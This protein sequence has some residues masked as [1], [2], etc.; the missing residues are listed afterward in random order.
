MNT[1]LL[2][3]TAQSYWLRSA[4]FMLSILLVSSV[5]TG[6]G[7]SEDDSKLLPPV[8][9][10]AGDECHV[11][12]MI[13]TNFPGPKGEAYERGSEV[14]LKFCSTR[15]LFSYLLQPE[16]QARVTQVYVHDMG[17]TD[18]EHPADNAFVDARS[19][20]YVADQPLK[21]AMGPTLA[22]FKTREDAQAFI[23]KHGGRLLR[24]KDI[25]LEILA[26]LGGGKSK[27]LPP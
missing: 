5:L 11:C 2:R 6:C 12:G 13:I 3:L 27:P 17:A 10:E 16:N 21:G 4:M 18:W 19:A 8:S 23:E 25:T 22:S 20:W 26:T 7:K 14:P 15:D 24:F 9:I 1:C